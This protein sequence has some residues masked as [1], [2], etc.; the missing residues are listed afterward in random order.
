MEGEKY[1]KNIIIIRSVNLN[2]A[3]SH[4][5]RFNAIVYRIQGLEPLEF[6]II[7]SSTGS[8]K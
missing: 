5:K 6:I 1:R 7:R 2:A 3:T 4:G 8:K